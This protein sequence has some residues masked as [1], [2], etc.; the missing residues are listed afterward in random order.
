MITGGGV[1]GVGG[2]GGDSSSTG[3][4]T[5]A[6][7]A[8]NGGNTGA[9][10]ANNGGAVGQGGAGAMNSGGAGGSSGGGGSGG[11]GG[12]S[13]VGDLVVTTNADENDVGATATAP[14]GTGLSLR[15]AITISNA[16]PGVQSITFKS[17]VVVAPSSLLPSFTEPAHLI[18]G[19]VNWSAIVNCLV[20]TASSTLIDGIEVY[21]CKGRPILVSSGSGTQVTNCNLHDNGQ[22]LE[23]LAGATPSTIG[24]NNVVRNSGSHGIAIYADNSEVTGNRVFD[25]A[26][27]DL[28]ISG[29]TLN[30]RVVGNLL[31]RAGTSGIGMGATTANVVIWFNTVVE[32]ANTG[33]VVGQ[34]S[35]IDLRDNILAYNT[36]YGVVG[37]DSKFTQQDYNLFFGN[38]SGT[39]NPC[40]LGP[41][42]VLADPLFVNCAADDFTL[43]AA[44]PAGNVGIDLAV[45]RNGAGAGN[46]NG[47]APD[48]GY[49]ESP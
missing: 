23:V 33:V 14:G 41:H 1:A 46:F 9:G 29:G 44:S 13:T 16:T 25:S 27:S 43:Q 2:A 38:G 34:A 18:G 32:N 40:T 8:N 45:D 37:T 30:T 5:S 47:S 12:T 35:G 39:C 31:V 19:V 28:F 36:L 11:A 49:W 7:G 4:N 48:L 3:G 17:G 42:T 20:I 22:P 24:P 10:G 15:E 6:G 26:V 21:G